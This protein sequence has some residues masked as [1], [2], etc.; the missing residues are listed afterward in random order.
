MIGFATD[1][2]DLGETSPIPLNGGG[3]GRSPGLTQFLQ[4]SP[5][6]HY[7]A[8]APISFTPRHISSRQPRTARGKPNPG[9]PGRRL[10]NVIAKVD[11]G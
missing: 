5:A 10:T 2:D 4:Q 3:Q 9:S 6:T 11:W 1:G 7:L 8:P